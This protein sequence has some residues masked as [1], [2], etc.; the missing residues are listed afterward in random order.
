MSSTIKR[1][2]AGV[3]VLATLGLAGA[4]YVQAGGDDEGTATGPGAEAAKAA[5]LK[6]IAG[7]R[8]N[9]VERDG[10]KGA[11]GEGEVTRPDGAT[12]DVRLGASY[13]LVAV[14]GDS[15]EGDGDD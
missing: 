2:V 6:V 8:V 14:D 5:A 13:E 15:E 7:G 1:T 10:E 3:A 4:A 11:T 9:A 12:V